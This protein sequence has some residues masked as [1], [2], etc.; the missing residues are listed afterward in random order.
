MST[1]IVLW[2]KAI[3]LAATLPLLA[4]AAPATASTV[5]PESG[6]TARLQSALDRL[7]ADGVPG[8]LALRR[9]G[10]QVWRATSRVSDVHSGVG[11]DQG[12]DV[13]GG[14]RS[15][16]RS[17]AVPGGHAARCRATCDRCTRI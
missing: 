5:N 3:F 4:G 13:D 17:H 16:A 6:T 14:C 1:P 10:Y 7:V 9:N 8:V 2:R 15:G 11:A 12:S